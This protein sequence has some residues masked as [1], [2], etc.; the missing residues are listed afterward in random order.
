MCSCNTYTVTG[1]SFISTTVGGHMAT[2]AKKISEDDRPKLHNMYYSSI[3]LEKRIDKAYVK[4]VTANPRNSS[5]AKLL[6]ELLDTGLKA[7]KC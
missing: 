4:Q 3:N 6:R 1:I 5:R 7:R 2:N